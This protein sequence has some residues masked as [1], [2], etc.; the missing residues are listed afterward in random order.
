MKNKIRS[1]QVI[2]A[3]LV[4]LIIINCAVIFKFSAEESGKSSDRSGK[5][6]QKIVEVNPRT[7]NLEKKEK[8]RIQENLIVPIRKTAHFSVY[9]CLGA[10]IFILANTYKIK[11][12]RKILISLI[13]AFIYACSDEI[14][15]LF[16]GGRSGEFR[17]VCIDTCG[18]MFGIILVL[19]ICAC[20]HL[21]K[22]KK[23]ENRLA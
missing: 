12:F 3:V 19:A 4:I 8:D 16:V 15:Q 23:E 22:R 20:I 13:S 21:F 17:D 2:R 10:L 1:K 6:V 7:R 11:D 18:A 9:M 14:H 5:V